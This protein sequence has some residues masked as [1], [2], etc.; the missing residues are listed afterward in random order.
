[1]AGISDGR[2]GLIG[3]G[4]NAPLYTTSFSARPKTQEDSELHENRLAEA[5]DLDRTARVLEFRDRDV[6]PHPKTPENGRGKGSRP[7]PRTIWRGTE[8]L[9][10]GS[11]R[12]MYH[13]YSGTGLSRS[14]AMTFAF[15]STKSNA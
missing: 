10:V 4:T 15:P 8:W 6:S 12:S 2:G 14:I 5:L 11:D 7:I 13:F 3:S 9:M 1:M